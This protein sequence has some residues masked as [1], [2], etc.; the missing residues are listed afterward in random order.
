MM[1]DELETFVPIKAGKTTTPWGVNII[2]PSNE[3]TAK[4]DAQMQHAV[5]SMWKMILISVICA[6]AAILLLWMKLEYLKIV[7]CCPS[8]ILLVL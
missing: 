1:G 3:I 6:F 7:A 4:A 5:K 2:I 8:E